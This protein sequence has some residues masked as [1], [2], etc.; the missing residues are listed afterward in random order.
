MSF[1]PAKVDPLLFFQDIA[2]E[3][4][5]AME[6][7]YRLIKRGTYDAAN[8]YIQSQEGICGYF[9]VFFNAI[10]NRIDNLQGHLLTLVP[11]QPFVSSDTEP[12]NIDKITI[13]I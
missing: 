12:Q 4:A 13:W 11:K 10:E 6:T 1:Y 5:N 3:K 7:Y 2:L 9:A 8:K